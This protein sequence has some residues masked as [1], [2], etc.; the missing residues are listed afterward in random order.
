MSENG[1]DGYETEKNREMGNIIESGRYG[2]IGRKKNAL[3]SG[4]DRF[5][6]DFCGKRR[7][8]VGGKLL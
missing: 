5:N 2:W 7:R 4:V 8:A 6:G 3:V 1:I